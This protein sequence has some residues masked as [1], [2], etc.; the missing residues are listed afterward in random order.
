[1]PRLTDE[2]WEKVRAEYEVRGKTMLGLSKEFG[3][4]IAA[5][6]RKA[7]SQTW[8]QG[9]SQTLVEKK[10]SVVK[11]LAEVEIESQTLTPLEKFTVEDVVRERLQAEGMLASFD[12]ALMQTGVRVLN[13]VKDPSAWESMTRGRRNL[14]PERPATGVN[15]NVNQNSTAQAAAM[16]TPTPQPD[17]ALRKAL[18]GE[19]NGEG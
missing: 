3:I 4:D 6:S 1:M 15:V 9:K 5:I 18:R 16:P 11:Q 2:Q 13:S 7:K 14:S 19:F 8:I 12:L 17:A 10:V